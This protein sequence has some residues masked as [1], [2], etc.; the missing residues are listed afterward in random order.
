[1]IGRPG[2]HGP[3]DRPGDGGGRAPASPTNPF[4]GPSW[5]LGIDPSIGTP[6]VTWALT[7]A[8][9]VIAFA[10]CL[11]PIRRRSD[12]AAG[13]F[14]PVAASEGIVGA[15]G[16]SQQVSPVASQPNEIE[17]PVQDVRPPWLRRVRQGE[18]PGGPDAEV[19]AR[20]PARF[21]TPAR[22]GVERHLITYRWVR[23]S[24]GPDERASSE[25]GRLDRGDEIEV[26]GEYEGSLHVRT[27]DGLEGWV[28]RV[29]IV[30]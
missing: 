29:V 19:V 20:V 11:W 4:D 14:N 23:L 9:G 3:D 15:A 2:G 18:R 8:F 22:P 10:V 25:V 1:M 6:V 17:L 24:D 27:S 26:I 13:R 28:P 21:A 30:G 7:T 16:W 5:G 12:D